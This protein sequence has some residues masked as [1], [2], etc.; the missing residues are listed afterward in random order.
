MLIQPID[1]RSA[2]IGRETRKSLL[3]CVLKKQEVP[4]RGCERDRVDANE[5]ATTV[6]S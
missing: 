2:T 6:D 3:L 5:T 1:V 4:F